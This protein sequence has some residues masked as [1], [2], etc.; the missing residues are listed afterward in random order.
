MITAEA[1][2]LFRRATAIERTGLD[3]T[4]EKDGGCRHEY[5]DLREEPRTT[6]GLQVWETGPL[7]VDEDQ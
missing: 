6:L 7:S 1:I 3:E 5:L 4:L 2:D